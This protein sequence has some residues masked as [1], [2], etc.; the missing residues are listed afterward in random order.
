MGSTP[1][2]RERKKQREEK[3]ARD[4]EKAKEQAGMVEIDHDLV[5]K[6]AV[7]NLR[8]TLVVFVIGSGTD[9]M[10]H[11]TFAKMT[12]GAAIGVLISNVIAV[13]REVERQLNEL[14]TPQERQEHRDEAMLLILEGGGGRE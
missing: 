2:S 5:L 13:D 9:K 8:D 7:E 1:E 4:T 12:A 10:Y 11:G 14:Y 6:V 3:K